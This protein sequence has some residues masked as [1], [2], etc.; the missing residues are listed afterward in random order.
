[1][2]FFVA[3]VSTATSPK[4]SQSPIPISV[5]NRDRPAIMPTAPPK[6]APIA[7]HS[8]MNSDMLPP[9]TAKMVRPTATSATAHSIRHTLNLGSFIPI[10]KS[11]PSMH[12]RRRP[13]S[14]LPDAKRARPNRRRLNY[15][16]LR[17]YSPAARI[18]AAGTA[19]SIHSAPSVNPPASPSG[20]AAGKPLVG[21]PNTSS[22]AIAMSSCL[23]HFV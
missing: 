9:D 13:K 5:Q 14:V 11:L 3:Y 8:K 16:C 10:A 17:K 23:R 4:T 18:V 6:L 22:P 1:M 19:A 15:C 12:Q 7:A 2:T 21:N 20:G